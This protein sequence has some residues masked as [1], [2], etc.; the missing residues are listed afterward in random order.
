METSTILETVIQSALDLKA[1]NLIQ[2]DME[3][4]SS[5]S[6]YILICHGTSSAHAQGI[7]DKINMTMKKMDHLPMGIEGYEDGSWILIDCSSV[8]IHIFTE[9]NRLKYNLEELYTDFKT[10]EI[11]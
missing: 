10:T 9:D 6:D 11:Q 1:L 3:E 2:I 7:A 8:I 4:R 5:L